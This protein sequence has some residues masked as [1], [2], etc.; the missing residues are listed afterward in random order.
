[1]ALWANIEGKHIGL[2]TDVMQNEHFHGAEAIY[3]LIGNSSMFC[4][5]WRCSLRIAQGEMVTK[6][7]GAPMVES[8]WPD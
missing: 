8:D 5:S 6:K 2:V 4:L 7:R 3:L 1:M